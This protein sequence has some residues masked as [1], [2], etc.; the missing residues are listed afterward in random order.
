[1]S[2][3]KDNLR[4]LDIRFVQHMFLCILEIVNAVLNRHGSAAPRRV[5]PASLVFEG[6]KREDLRVRPERA[7]RLG[8]ALAERGEIA[9]WVVTADGEPGRNRG[10]EKRASSRAN[11]AA[12]GKTARRRLSIPVR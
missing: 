5:H 2:P 9:Y 10:G 7:R 6:I 8:A 1:M 12:F 11:A 3:A 4:E